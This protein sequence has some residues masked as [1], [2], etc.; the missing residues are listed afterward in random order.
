MGTSRSSQ[1]IWLAWSAMTHGFG[2]RTKKPIQFPWSDEK[3]PSS[4][5][6]M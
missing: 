3:S 2:L 5:K 1:Y 4:E 6:H